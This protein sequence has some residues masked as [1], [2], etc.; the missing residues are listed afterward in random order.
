VLWIKRFDT[1]QELRTAVR[2]LTATYNH[3]WPLE[4]HSYHTPIEA[5]EHYST[6]RRRLHERQARAG[7]GRRGDS[8]V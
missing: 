3:E 7:T 4:R 6:D 1:F 5:R 8:C 2:K